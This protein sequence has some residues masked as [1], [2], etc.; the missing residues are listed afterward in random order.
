MINKNKLRRTRKRQKGGNEDTITE[1]KKLLKS[2]AYSDAK[3][4]F[5][6]VSGVKYYDYDAAWITTKE[7]L[8]LWKNQQIK[9]VHYE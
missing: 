9:T 1:Y 7:L 4:D 2:F 8:H 6:D 3:H 5:S